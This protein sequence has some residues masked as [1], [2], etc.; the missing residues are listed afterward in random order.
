M[1]R[2]TFWLTLIAIGIT[3]FH[4]IGLDHDHVV[5]FH[6]SI[7]AWILPAFTN[8]QTMDKYVVYFLT[9]TS[10]FYIGLALDFLVLRI[11]KQQHT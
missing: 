5:L 11:R 7:P 9:I 8:I 4:A 6:V 2:F 1:G 3:I 10:W